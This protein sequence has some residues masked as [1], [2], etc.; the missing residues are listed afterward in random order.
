MAS[1]SFPGGAGK[2]K[3][4]WVGGGPESSVQRCCVNENLA[5]TPVSVL[6]EGRVPCPPVQWHRAWQ[7][8]QS[9]DQ[10]MDK[11]SVGPCEQS[12]HSQSP[13]EKYK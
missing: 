3:R 11:V 2:S 9:R 13:L 12:L 7:K 10:G 8:P 6:M 5:M 1:D 4:L